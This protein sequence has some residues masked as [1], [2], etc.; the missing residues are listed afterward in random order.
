MCHSG[1][2]KSS[3]CCKT[4]SCCE[5][6]RLCTFL[7]EF[8][9]DDESCGSSAKRNPNS[10]VHVGAEVFEVRNSNLCMKKCFADGMSGGIDLLKG[11]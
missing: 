7:R 1:G 2:A 8:N 11:E 5:K 4:C 3:G 10:G 9:T 6:R